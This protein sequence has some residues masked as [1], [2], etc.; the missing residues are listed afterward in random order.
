MQRVLSLRRRYSAAAAQ[1]AVVIG[2]ETD[3]WR[4][5]IACFNSFA[6]CVLIAHLH[7]QRA[8][9]GL[10][11]LDV[12]EG[13]TSAQPRMGQSFRAEPLELITCPLLSLDPAGSSS[14]DLDNLDSNKVSLELQDI[15]EAR[16]LWAFLKRNLECA[17]CGTGSPTGIS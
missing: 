4:Q 9:A 2:R 8:G 7:L 10:G 15:A 16:K 3:H 1:A 6:C 11:D 5:G 17:K 14:P 13:S 12:T